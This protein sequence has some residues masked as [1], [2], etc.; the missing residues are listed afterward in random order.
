MKWRRGLAEEIAWETYERTSENLG[1]EHRNSL[2]ALENLAILA[3][4]T[5][6]PDEAE[7]LH[8]EIL[9]IRRRTLGDRHSDTLTSLVN[10]G[11]QYSKTGRLAEGEELLREA[12]ETARETL[13]PDNFTVASFL[14]A[15]GENLYRQ[16][17]FEEAREVFEEFVARDE[18]SPNK[19]AMG[20]NK[21]DTYLRAIA[22]RTAAPR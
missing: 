8:L 19:G 21:V 10:L 12:V 9:S 17:R 5:E 6:R 18:R 13:G 14:L 3:G 22:E 16:R 7:G 11:H 20:R 15:L 1:P 2:V 4:R